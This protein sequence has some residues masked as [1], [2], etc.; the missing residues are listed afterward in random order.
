[1]EK[2]MTKKDCFNALLEIGAVASNDGLVEF[3]N[4]EIELLDKKNASSKKPSKTQLEN[5]VI[6]DKIVETLQSVDTPVRINDLVVAFDN[7]FSNQK[8]SALVKQLVDSGKVVKSTDKK[9]STFTL[10]E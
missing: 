8:I 2:K 7:Q 4:H 10:A 1:M 6:K 5:E 9:V 3:I